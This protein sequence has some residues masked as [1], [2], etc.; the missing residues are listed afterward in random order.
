MLNQAILY[1]GGE[2]GIAALIAAGIF[3][4]V[5][6][7]ISF[8]LLH[9]IAAALLGAVGVFLVAYIWGA[10]NP[11]LRLLTFEDAMAVVDWNVIALIMGMMIFMGFWAETRV[12]RWLSFQMYK[13]P[14]GMPC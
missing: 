7:A 1:S 2:L 4:F 8:H 3:L 5:F 6:I 13:K 10:Y 9:E 12:F 11:T 14:K